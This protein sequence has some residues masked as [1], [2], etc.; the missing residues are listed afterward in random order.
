[1]VFALFYDP[2]LPACL[3][4]V[5]TPQVLTTAILDIVHEKMKLTRFN[6]PQWHT[7][8]TELYNAPSVIE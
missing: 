6:P 1:M 3:C 7:G 2:Y 5:P 8:S 4:V